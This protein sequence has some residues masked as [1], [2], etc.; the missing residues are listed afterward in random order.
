MFTLVIAREVAC[1]KVDGHRDLRNGDVLG[2]QLKQ[3]KLEPCNFICK[4]NT[5]IGQ[6]LNIE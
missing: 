1:F 6:R 4:Y 2:I 3:L 5:N